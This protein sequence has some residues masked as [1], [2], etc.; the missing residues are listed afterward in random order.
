MARE[1]KRVHGIRIAGAMLVRKAGV[2]L[3]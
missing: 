3:D 1:A 2:K